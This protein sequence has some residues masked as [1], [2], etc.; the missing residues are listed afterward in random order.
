MGVAE[1]AIGRPCGRLRRVNARR[2]EKARLC[3]RALC[4]PLS[5]RL[6]Q[7]AQ[8]GA[9]ANEGHHDPDVVRRPQHFVCC[10]FPELRTDNEPK[11]RR[12]SR[13]RLWHC[14]C[15]IFA[16]R[17]VTSSWPRRAG[18]ALTGASGRRTKTHATDASMCDPDPNLA[19]LGRHLVY[20]Q[21]LCPQGAGGLLE[22]KA[23]IA[24]DGGSR[25]QTQFDIRRRIAQTAEYGT[26]GQ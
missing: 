6:A 8:Q 13:T 1:S 12:A 22:S 5:R 21:V 7:L 19:F 16:P 18:G 10:Q 23:Q 25:A 2:L 3:P 11:N 4:I 9:P 15:A 14:L 20:A 26:L 17:A 24:E